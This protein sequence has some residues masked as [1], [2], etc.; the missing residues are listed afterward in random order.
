MLE[1]RLESRYRKR[2]LCRL[3]QGPHRFAGVVLNVSRSGLFVQT[4]ASPEIGAEIH[5]MLNQHTRDTPVA[6]TAEVVWQRRVPPALRSSATGG[7]GLRIR[8]APE[9]YYG[10]LAE[11]A[12][13]TIA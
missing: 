6:L 5:V 12:R 13:R 7:L 4:S 9:P 11:A 2:V 3:K 1:G 8:Y 10:L